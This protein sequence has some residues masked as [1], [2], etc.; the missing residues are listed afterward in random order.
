[1]LGPLYDAF[2]LAILH[3]LINLVKIFLTH[4]KKVSPVL[5]MTLPD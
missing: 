3:L 4:K 1:M 2:Q 5:K